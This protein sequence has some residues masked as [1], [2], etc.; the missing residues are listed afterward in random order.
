MV[1]SVSRYSE[2]VILSWG[3]DDA[4]A[5][6]EGRS[7][8]AVPTMILKRARRILAQLNAAAVIGD[9]GSP[10]GNMLHKLKGTNT[11][12]VRVNEQHR[13]TLQWTDEGPEEVRLGDYH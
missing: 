9:M 6:F 4:K 2:I 5:V 11:W 7:P 8:R 3:N 13:V 12:A 1:R 10:P